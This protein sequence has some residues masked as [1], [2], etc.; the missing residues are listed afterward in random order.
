MIT[1]DACLISKN[2]MPHVDDLLRQLSTC[3]THVYLVDTGSD[4]GF[5]DEGHLKSLPDN[6]HVSS[7][8]W[9]QDF[10]EARNKSFSL[11]DS[12]YIFWCDC[13]DML[14]DELVAKLQDLISNPTISYDSLPDWIG[15]SEIIFESHEPLKLNESRINSI[16]IYYKNTKN[17]DT[18]IL[19]IPHTCVM[20]QGKNY[21]DV[22]LRV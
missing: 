16:N 20:I 13:D 17:I 15:E 10:S 7:H 1:I 22:F 12:Q 6:V 14:S 3:M 5:M 8:E 11:G 9:K 2:E 4:D 19:P 21:S 18:K